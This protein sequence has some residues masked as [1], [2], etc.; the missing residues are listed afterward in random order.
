LG[1][2][3]IKIDKNGLSKPIHQPV[4]FLT[5]GT[6]PVLLWD[7]LQWWVHALDMANIIA[8]M[9]AH[10]QAIAVIVPG[11]HYTIFRGV[12]NDGRWQFFLDLCGAHGVI[13]DFYPVDQLFYSVEWDLAE[14]TV[15][16]DRCPA[17]NARM[18]ENVLAA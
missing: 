3:L 11:A 6:V 15:V 8:T 16:R 7:I 10:Q 4:G 17:D 18:A 1:L 13:V 5:V 14:R 9:V 2:K 12:F